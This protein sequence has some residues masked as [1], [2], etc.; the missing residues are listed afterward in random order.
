MVSSAAWWVVDVSAGGFGASPGTPGTSP[1]ISGQVFGDS[2]SAFANVRFEDVQ[3]GVRIHPVITTGALTAAGANSVSTPAKSAEVTETDAVLAVKELTPKRA[4]HSFSYTLEDALTYPG[5]E[6]GLRANLRAG[7]RDKVDEQIL[8]RGTDG[9]LTF[10]TEPTSPTAESTAAQ[11]LAAVASGVDGRFAMNEGEVKA[12]V[13][14]TIYGHMAGQDVG[15]NSGTTVTDKLGNRV[16]VSPHVA[17]YASNYQEAVVCKGSAFQAVCA[18]WQGVPIE[19]AD[20]GSR[21]AHGE[22]QLFAFLF[23]DFAILRTDGYTRHRFRNS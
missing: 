21:A 18:I 22:V 8:N 7:L 16:R 14:S 4:Q 3:P 11:Y 17:A 9:L 12:L 6:I 23:H 2:A 10:G 19:V 20:R 15:T 13:G 1:G 5:L